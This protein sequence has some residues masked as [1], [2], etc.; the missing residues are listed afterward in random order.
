MYHA[1]IY[2]CISNYSIC[3]SFAAMF[4]FMGK[5]HIYNGYE[6]KNHFDQHFDDFHNTLTDPSI[7]TVVVVPDGL[8]FTLAR[9]QLL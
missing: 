5:D 6:T 3:P 8:D 7:A 1:K 9:P 2:A 4:A